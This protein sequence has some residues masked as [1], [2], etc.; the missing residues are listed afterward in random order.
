MG[1]TPA[2]MANAASERS[3]PGGRPADQQLRGGDRPHA[4]LGQQRRRQRL[5]HR[6]QLLAE[7]LGLLVSGQH[8][9]GGQPQ[10]PD[11]RAVLDRVGGR[12]DKAAQACA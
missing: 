12:S 11:G 1:A 7:L 8:A 9:L 10:R 4:R 2:S 6:P 5:H 3:R